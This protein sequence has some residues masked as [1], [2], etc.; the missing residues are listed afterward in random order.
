MKTNW[1]IVVVVALIRTEYRNEETYQNGSNGLAFIDPL[2][3]L[4][5]IVGPA[6]P[7]IAEE[8]EVKDESGNQTTG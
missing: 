6:T 1:T 2:S 5:V 3:N 8:R 4:R 7:W